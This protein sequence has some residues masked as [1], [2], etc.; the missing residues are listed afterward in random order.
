MKT[1][2]TKYSDFLSAIKTDSLVYL[3]G[4]GMSAALTGKSYSWWQW[5]T[6]GIHYMA[7]T[8][9][10]S[11]LEKS[12]EADDSTTNMI[13]IV[14][15]VIN[16]TKADGTYTSWMQEAFEKNSIVNT[17]LAETIRKF[18][19]T[20]DIL[21]TT[22]YDLLLEHATGM[23]PLSY[24]E[25]NT[26][27]QMLD[28]H[29]ST[30]VLHI[31]GIYDSASGRDNIVASEE[32]YN[33]VIENQ[34]AQFIQ[35]ILGTRTLIFAGCG[36]T[37]EDA[38]ISRFIKFANEQLKMDRTYY[39]LYN[40]RKPITNLPPNIVPIPYGDDYADLPEFL[41]DIAQIRI[42]SVID[43]NPVI[44]RTIYQTKYSSEDSLL[45]YH[46]SQESVEFCGREAEL[47]DLNGFINSETAFTWWSITGQA[48]SGKSRLAYQLLRT[49]PHSWFGFFLNDDA[50]MADIE[51]FTPFSNTVVVV[52][53][54]AG[55][56]RSVAKS[57]QNLAQR[58]A[59][60]SYK[61]RILLLER[62]SSKE[63]GSWYSILKQR[64]GKYD[65]LL[66]DNEYRKE[67]LDLKDLDIA[68]VNRLIGNVCEIHGLMSDAER[69]D[70]LSQAYG[71]KFEKLQ[72]RPLFVQLFVEAWISN[73]C[74]LP[75]YDSFEDVL[76]S[77]L[78]REQDRWLLA[79]EGDYA[80]CNAF[81]H[82]LLR[83]NISG[84]LDVHSLPDYYKEDGK[85]VLNF[86]SGHSF[87]GR[88]RSEYQH[89]LIN[90]VCQ[91]IDETNELIAP[92]FPDIIKEYM[93]CYYMEDER[94]PEVISE[95][96][97]NAAH[98][99]SVF[100]TRC[101]T[102]FPGNQ[103][104]KDA[105]NVYDKATDNVDVLK[106]RLELLQHNI[107][108]EDDNPR[109]LINIIA[110]EHEFWNS[111]AVPKDGSE[112]ADMIALLK[113]SGLNLV[114]RQIGGW[115]IYDLT[116]MLEAIDD[117]LKVEG[118]TVIEVMKEFYLQE[119]I[120]NLSQSGFLDEAAYLREKLDG[121]ID[122]NPEDDF[123]SLLKM[124][125]MNA[126]MMDHLLN[127]DAEGAFAVLQ[128]MAKQCDFSN[129]DSARVLAHS[130][131]NYDSFSF[132]I[133][134]NDCTGRGLNIIE[135]VSLLYRDDTEIKARTIGCKTFS[136]QRDYF[137][138]KISGEVL[139]SRLLPLK[140][141]LDHLKFC[142][143][144]SDEALGMTW[145]VVYTLWLNVIDD[146]ETALREVISSADSILGVN[147]SVSDV[148]TTKIT[149]VRVLHKKVLHSQITH[150]EVEDVFRYVEINYD[151]A[152]LRNEFFQM[153]SE[154]EDSANRDNYI[155]KAVAF[156][157]RQDA[158]YN[159]MMPSGIDEFDEEA[160]FLRDLYE[161]QPSE[162][163]RREHRKIGAN[164]PC[165][166]G[167]GKK[168]KK[169][170]RGNGKYD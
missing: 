109:V 23:R 157:A 129:I 42:R 134:R 115:S 92:L 28:Q 48:G 120:K 143:N 96:W 10:A 80:C 116:D 51:T 64:A 104:F 111:I 94:L 82:L 67:F 142:Q 2:I 79:F 133:E 19:I 7:D 89:N 86:I 21:A 1:D 159:L 144:A 119:H 141:E 90:S 30:H 101:L 103:F 146:D 121:I 166:C 114:A 76:K 16:A 63:D 153:L 130:C 118:G 68:A 53:Y 37:T 18:T 24:S 6:D 36:Q 69:D 98:D 93:F 40:S 151:S 158:R 100:L 84:T 72:F 113:V 145:G 52:D 3:L 110:N 106:G 95:L 45:R 139:K 138:E 105:V 155:T 149:A 131:F 70:A 75:E 4:A 85:T 152:S 43:R 50:A 137:A 150:D 170:C 107:I 147:A 165:P 8:E 164:D 148:V 25:P 27:F 125:N 20:Q 49:L 47:K 14:G 56:E 57:I 156:G 128:S 117:M 135:K 168:F 61:L 55:R 34:G 88:Q 123:S 87:P 66:N 46:Y 136:L 60:T 41:E 73:D 169:C 58:F 59:S 17:A 78:S 12:L 35:G 91:N 77:I 108:H 140:K 167:S 11:K 160:E 32:Q 162:P 124:H 26:A 127:E 39:F 74:T 65:T 154:S 132:Y 29:V 126:E 81:I 83:A 13:D 9:S 44:G 97:Q 33:A 54:V 22:N 102:D 161:Y 163:Y 5:I 31:H 122:Q 38:N 15:K 99:F 112:N 62:A 71:R